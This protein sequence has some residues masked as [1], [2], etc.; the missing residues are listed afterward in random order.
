MSVTIDATNLVLIDAADATTGW[1]SS[2][3]GLN[4]N[5]Q[6]PREGGVA[7]QDQGSEETFEVFHTITKED[8]TA[9]TIFGWQRSG[10]PS[11]EADPAGFAMYLGDG[12]AEVS[13]VAL[14]AAGTGYLVNDV[15][16]VSLGSGQLAIGGSD[17]TITVDSIGGGGDIL[18]FTL[19]TNGLY[20]IDPTPLTANPVTGGTGSGATFNLTMGDQKNQVAYA[21]GGSDNFGFFFQGWSMFRL[22]TA[23]LP[24][25]VR[26]LNGVA[27]N[28]DPAGITE[29]GYAGEFP[30]KAAGNSDNL[31]FDV[32]RYCANANP[33]LLIE[34]GLTGA[35]GTFQQ[36]TDADD[37]TN[38]AWGIIRLLVPGSK[39]FEVNFGF[40]IGSLD[41]DSWFEDADFQLF[42]NGDVP[43]AGAG[44]SAGSMDVV[45]AGE[46]GSTS[47]I[48]LADFLIQGLGT[49]SNWDASNV[50]VDELKWQRGTFTDLGTILLPVQEVGNKFLAD[51]VFN[52]CGQLV[53]DTCDMDRITLNGTT[54]G[55]GAMLLDEATHD[56]MTDLT[57]VSDGTG[58]AIELTP[59]GAGPFSFNWDDWKF[60]GY[61]AND[62]GDA[63]V[64]VDN[65]NDADVTI[66]IIGNGDIP[67]VTKAAGYTG[68]VTIVA[69]SVTT[70]VNVKDN[71]GNNLQNARVI[72]EASDAT[73]DLPFEE[74]VTITRSGTT[75]SVAHTGH[76]I[77]SGKKMVIRGSDDPL[78]N[79]VFVITNVTVNAY[80]YTMNGTPA[81]SPATGTILASGVILEGLT[82]ASGDIS[83]SRPITLNTPIKG[84]ARKSTS[85]PRFKSF[86]LAGTVDS[87]NGESINIRMILDE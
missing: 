9:R 75:A 17:A 16:T 68:T 87:S 34:G 53:P 52:N 66:T 29:V 33:A 60:S 56:N 82:D 61:G 78:Y 11:V 64:L 31:G 48:N 84:F 67:T 73:G 57:F 71:Q 80:D 18:T 58:H 79:G 72:L 7:L 50:D 45:I 59:V 22:N 74:G 51:V 21:V 2:M 19:T 12:A 41:S 20:I 83:D 8:Y 4:D 3:G 47:V 65:A 54:D 35:R 46:P 26:T 28:L 30:A 27:A 40:Q 70:A 25:N 43:D 13:S 69:G 81:A 37:D 39:A 15:L 23:D 77:A 55:N 10:G 86:T 1:T 32:L 62:T 49:V 76:G 44:I 6:P 38:N 63:V 85:S 24:T 42:I 36:V 14:N 5:Q